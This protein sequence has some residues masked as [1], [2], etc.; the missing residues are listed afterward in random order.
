MPHYKA[1]IETGMFKRPIEQVTKN[2]RYE[3][4]S[5]EMRAGDHR[6]LAA[7]KLLPP[8]TVEQMM[9]GRHLELRA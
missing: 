4:V 2:F 5:G 6:S 9:P 1:E 3:P 7:R 8:P